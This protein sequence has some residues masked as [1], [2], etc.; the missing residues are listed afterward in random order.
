MHSAAVG[1]D[2]TVSAT[3]GNDWLMLVATQITDPP[4]EAEF[5]AW[6]DDIDIPDVLEVP[7]YQRARRGLR[8]GTATSPVTSCPPTKGAM[9]RSTTF[10]PANIDKTIIEML[11]AT[12]KMEA[13]GRTTDLLKVTERVYYMR[14]APPV[15][16][17][18]RSA[19]R[20]RAAAR[21]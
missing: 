14:H 10:D 21:R 4:R 12:R 17:P 11:M 8:L 16:A 13:R 6:Y 5:N 7:G 3:A 15:E 2:G 20:A 18:R 9:S 19:C 1:A